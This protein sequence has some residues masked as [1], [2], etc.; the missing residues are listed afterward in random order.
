[1]K[2]ILIALL[3]LCLLTGCVNTNVNAPNTKLKIVTTLFPQFDF[4]R[5]IAG[6]LADVQLLLPPGSES[7]SYEPSPADIIA[8]NEADLFIYT[9]DD[10]EAWV[11]EV[12]EGLEGNPTILNLS[13]GMNLHHDHEG[14]NHGLDPHIFTSPVLAMQIAERIE[15]TLCN[16]DPQNSTIYQ[17]RGQAFIEE[18]R[19]LDASFEQIASTAK[20]NKLVFGGRFAFL[21]LTEAYGLSYEA[22]FDSC[23]ADSEPSSA[24]LA[25]IIDTVKNEQ[26][27]VV[28]YEE[29]TEP[30]VAQLICNETGA[31]PLLLHSCHNIS[32]DELSAG[33]TYLSIMKQ[34]A[35]HI[36]E[37]LN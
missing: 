26:I 21:Y 3:S 27:P 13:D 34:N 35:E 20:R 19:A 1:M 10:M 25:A 15:D 2:R 18:L 31:K 16:L 24:R 9:G 37:G 5:T 28:F 33:A 23:S 12:L 8:I 17:S 22:A 30:K 32:K 4:A 7:H 14:H 36:R 11:R 29:L 6:N